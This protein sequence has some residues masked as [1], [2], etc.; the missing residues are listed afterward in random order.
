[1]EDGEGIRVDRGRCDKD[2]T[3][4]GKGRVQE[5]SDKGCG[6]YTG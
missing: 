3:R 1:M 6:P 2:L 4:S 5:V